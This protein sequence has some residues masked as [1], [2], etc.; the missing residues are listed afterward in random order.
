MAEEEK[1]EEEEGKKEPAAEGEEEGSGKK[2]KKKLILFAVVGLVLIGAIGGGAF[3]MLS[4]GD[5][6][7]ELSAEETIKAEDTEEKEPSEDAEKKPEEG[8]EKKEDAKEE[9]KPKE[10][11]SKD[12]A[13]KDGEKEENQ[14]IDIDFGS[15]FKLSTFNMNLGNPLE[16]RYIRLDVS[17]EYRG[18]EAQKKELEK[19]VPQI[20]DVVVSVVS[21]KTREF[22]LA[23]DGKN[24]LRKELLTKINRF[25]S[26]PIESVFITD[27]LIE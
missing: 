15:S 10:G 19:R 23:P 8:K 20:R 24:Q 13:K 27:I 18:G 3:F 21:R 1:K 7:V 12:A 17:I 11:D 6:K 22:L 16:N 4:G 5:E 26:K 9:E 14:E 2:G 25:M